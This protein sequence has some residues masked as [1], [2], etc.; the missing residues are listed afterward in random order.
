MARKYLEINLL[1]VK[2]LYKEIFT[3]PLMD[4]NEHLYKC[5]DRLYS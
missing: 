2:D 4:T 5:K 3:I 1:Y